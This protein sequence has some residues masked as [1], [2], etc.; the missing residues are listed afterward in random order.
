MEDQ[1]DTAPMA[2]IHPTATVATP[3]TLTGNTTHIPEHL[4]IILDRLS[5]SSAEA[6]NQSKGALE[7]SIQLANQIE[8]T[9]KRMDI[10]EETSLQTHTT[11]TSIS[12]TLEKHGEMF[13]LL[14]SRLDALQP[15]PPLQWLSSAELPCSS[16]ANLWTTTRPPATKS[17]SRG[18]GVGQLDSAIPDIP[19]RI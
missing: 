10:L 3:S 18:G 16:P 12:A 4:Q 5:A 2:V 8:E 6:L 19:R 15:P 13:S 7:A 14:L 9:N 17:H 1:A 11:V